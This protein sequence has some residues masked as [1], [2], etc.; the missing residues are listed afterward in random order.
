MYDL[1]SFKWRNSLENKTDSTSKGKKI[2]NAS[3]LTRNQKRNAIILSPK[4]GSSR[5]GN[6]QKPEAKLKNL[7]FLTYRQGER[8]GWSVCDPEWAGSTNPSDWCSTL[9]QPQEI[10]DWLLVLLGLAPAGSPK[11]KK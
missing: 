11:I 2:F 7:N 1:H 4:R 3:V 8:R 6:P 5:V 10:W 9:C